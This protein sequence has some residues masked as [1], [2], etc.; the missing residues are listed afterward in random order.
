MQAQT[1]QTRLVD[2]ILAELDQEAEATRRL[3][4]IVPEDKLSWQPHPK[5]MTLGQLALHIAITQGGVAQGTLDDTADA[6]DFIHPEAQTRD[7]IVAAFDD[8]LKKAKEIVSA[9]SDERALAEWKIV[10]GEKVL[11]AMPRI[12]FWRTVMLNHVYHHRGQ[13]STY[14]RQLDIPLPSV[15]GPTADTDGMV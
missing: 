15:Y 2:P 1:K 4:Q 7:E 12:A 8:G 14:L 6:P 9:T 5:A 10:D 11:L 3:L 13:L